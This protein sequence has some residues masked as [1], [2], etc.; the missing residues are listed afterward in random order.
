MSPGA[1]A[2]LSIL[3]TGRE[4]LLYNS[5]STFP[6]QPSPC[7]S[8]QIRVSA[9]LPQPT[10]SPFP[11]SLALPTGGGGKRWTALFPSPPPQTPCT[12]WAQLFA[13]L[14]CVPGKVGEANPPPAVPCLFDAED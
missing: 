3:L 8:A 11:V 14:M 12:L 13:L 4:L 7:S 6:T 9:T 5:V 1:S 2:C 10:V